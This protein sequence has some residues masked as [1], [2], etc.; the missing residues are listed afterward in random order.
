MYISSCP[1]SISFLFKVCPDNNL[2]KMGSIGIGCTVDKKVF[3]SV[4]KAEKTVVLLNGK[5]IEF[6]TVSYVIDKL[7]QSPVRVTIKSPLPLGSGFGI[8]GA[9]ALSCAHSLDKLFHLKKT[10]S[11]LSQIAH[12]AEIIN[13]TGLGS[14]GTQ[15]TGGFLLK[16]KSGL[17][18]SAIKLPFTGQK[19]Y[20]IIIGKL[21]TPS[22]LKDKKKIQEVNK[23]TDYYLL[24]LKNKKN[25]QLKDVL[26]ASYEFVSKTGLLTDKK[27]IDIICRIKKSG[28]SA[29]MAILGKVVISNIK[30]N[31]N[32]DYPLEELMIT[33]N[34]L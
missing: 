8:S 6:P 11:V 30:P 18:V 3:V 34:H 27:M 23:V 24:Q 2:L 22:I 7:T 32:I 29:T 31:F 14:V 19:I 26:D 25:I 9:S 4:E 21:L 20:A 33:N 17:P 15:I 5:P 28:G 12:T 13:K 16:T 10:K 1:A